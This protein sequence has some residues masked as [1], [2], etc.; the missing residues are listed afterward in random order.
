MLHKIDQSLRHAQLIP[1]A[2]I[3]SLTLVRT[4]TEPLMRNEI[5]NPSIV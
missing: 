5:L 1:L 2:S 3:V 4:H